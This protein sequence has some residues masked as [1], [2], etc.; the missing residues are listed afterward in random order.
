MRVCPRPWAIKLANQ[1][2]PTAFQ[3]LCMALAI[4]TIDA[5]LAVHFT[6]KGI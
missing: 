6:V 4:N 3:F 5:V 1:I 2:S